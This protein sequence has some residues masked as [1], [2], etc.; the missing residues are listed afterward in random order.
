M[1]GD[2][3]NSFENE[4]RPFDSGLNHL[5]SMRITD[6]L[7]KDGAS[8]SALRAILGSS[9]FENS[10]SALYVV[11]HD[12][13]LRLRGVPFVP[14]RLYRIKGGN[15]IMTDT[16]ATKLGERLRLGCPVGRSSTAKAASP[17]ITVSSAGRRRWRPISWCVA[18]HC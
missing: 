15:Q 4:Y 9:F 11:W 12:A 1:I 10:S 16:F 17:F 8:T 7:K 13:I 3:T 6:L 2:R 5:D 18:R 14:P